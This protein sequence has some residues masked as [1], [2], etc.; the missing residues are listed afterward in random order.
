M[1]KVVLV[2]PP[3]RLHGK[4][5]YT[6]AVSNRRKS[7][8]LRSLQQV[9]VGTLRVGLFSFDVILV[10]DESLQLSAQEFYLF[11]RH[12]VVTALELLALSCADDGLQTW[13]QHAAASTQSGH[14]SHATLPESSHV[15]ALF[16]QLQ[17][18]FSGSRAQLM[19][20]D[21]GCKKNM[22]TKFAYSYGEE[23]ETKFDFWQSYLA[24]LSSSL[25]IDVVVARS[26]FWMVD[27]GKE[28]VGGRDCSDG[29]VFCWSQESCR[30]WEKLLNA[31]ATYPTAGVASLGAFTARASVFER[32]ERLGVVP[33]ISQASNALPGQCVGAC[34]Y[35]RLA[36]LIGR[37]DKFPLH[38]IDVVHPLCMA[39]LCCDSWS[40]QCGL[41]FD[42]VD[43]QLN[44]ASSALR[45]F[46]ALL[47]S[48]LKDRT[49]VSARGEVTWVLHRVGDDSNLLSRG[50]AANVNRVMGELVDDAQVTTCS[51]S[52]LRQYQIYFSE[53][54]VRLLSSCCSLSKR[55]SLTLTFQERLVLTAT[56]AWCEQTLVGTFAHGRPVGVPWLCRSVARTSGWEHPGM[57]IRFILD[58]IEPGHLRYLTYTGCVTKSDR[59]SV[60]RRVRLREMLLVHEQFRNCVEGP[61]DSNR[62]VRL[63]RLMI[64]L[65]DSNMRLYMQD[66]RWVP[67]SELPEL[68]MSNVAGLT[69]C[70]IRVD[71]S[72]QLS[73]ADICD[74][75][76]ASSSAQA[77]PKW[78]F[79]S[80]S[81][82]C[83]G[84]FGTIGVDLIRRMFCEQAREF[85][86]T[87]RREDI[88]GV[89]AVQFP[90]Q[91]AERRRVPAGLL[92]GFHPANFFETGHR[93]IAANRV[94]VLAGVTWEYVAV[95]ELPFA[96]WQG[97]AWQMF[98]QA[99]AWTS[100]VQA[101]DDAVHGRAQF[102]KFGNVVLLGLTVRLALIHKFAQARNDSAIDQLLRSGQA[103]VREQVGFV[104]EPTLLAELIQRKFRRQDGQ[105]LAVFWQADFLGLFRAESCLHR[106]RRLTRS[107]DWVS[108][109]TRL[110]N[111]GEF[112]VD[113]DWIFNPCGRQ[114]YRGGSF[115]IPQW[116]VGLPGPDVCQRTQVNWCFP[117]GAVE[118]RA[119]IEVP[120][121]I[122]VPAVLAAC[123]KYPGSSRLSETAEAGDS[124]PS[125]APDDTRDTRSVLVSPNLVSQNQRD[126]VGGSRRSR[127]RMRR[128]LPHDPESMS[129]LLV[130]YLRDANRVGLQWSEI[131]HNVLP[132]ASAISGLSQLMLRSWSQSVCA[133]CGE[134]DFQWTSIASI[135]A[136]G[137]LLRLIEALRRVVPDIRF[138]DQV[139]AFRCLSQTGDLDLLSAVLV[140]GALQEPGFLCFIVD[141]EATGEGEVRVEVVRVEGAPTC[142]SVVSAGML[143]AFPKV[144]VRIGLHCNC[145]FRVVGLCP[146]RIGMALTEFPPSLAVPPVASIVDPNDAAFDALEAT[147][148]ATFEYGVQAEHA[149]PL[150]QTLWP[151]A[152][153]PHRNQPR[154]QSKTVFCRFSTMILLASLGRVVL[155]NH[156]REKRDFVGC[157]L[158][159][160]RG[161][162]AVA[163][164]PCYVASIDLLAGMRQVPRRVA[165]QILLF[166]QNGLYGLYTLATVNERLR[167]IFRNPDKSWLTAL[168][169]FCSHCN[170][171]EFWFGNYS[172]HKTFRE[173]RVL[174]QAAVPFLASLSESFPR[175]PPQ[176][177]H[178]TVDWSIHEEHT[179]CEIV[180]IAMR[181]A[182]RKYP[183]PAFHPLPTVEIQ[184]SRVG[185]DDEDAE[186]RTI[187][188][189][190]DDEPSVSVGE[191]LFAIV[192]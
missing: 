143:L 28:Y 7:R 60:L 42:A 117:T 4:L 83:H 166:W 155:L 25:R 137:V 163:H 169:G 129:A 97:T 39:I 47:A 102:D 149:E 138:A 72:H 164:L 147:L 120:E 153:G 14:G 157:D 179:S 79:R 88:A 115:P 146:V 1:T 113:R 141:V 128:D 67:E 15:C 100:A 87:W 19:L 151:S 26:S 40:P 71:T 168:R 131:C 167:H 86:H 56:V 127:V 178:L 17:E 173:A 5:L 150:K 107:S 66:Q 133:L 111:C 181:E 161:E 140:K 142:S 18:V 50:W 95:V 118:G 99:T 29:R 116:A 11:V 184:E 105:Q 80:V 36:S 55:C 94:G 139:C 148:R 175:C 45:K 65:Y 51:T 59:V 63:M 23:T 49:A 160:S 54:L 48:S 172:A 8:L 52:S 3:A 159:L 177:R 182:F 183:G 108:N 136:D 57:A 31:G 41:N 156:F 61:S 185:R 186:P 82:Q 22:C 114:R 6:C 134:L 106:L 152:E 10:Q 76:F 109:Y 37:N 12:K 34:L 16:G 13:A 46:N 103:V 33:R 162:A 64:L 112:D 53:L 119:S 188:L 70:G 21:L 192:D 123:A 104:A 62:P 84:Y 190:S 89:S 125:L 75:F 92:V 126:C 38:V 30:A 77:H 187:E 24:I 20:L 180:S 144:P 27:L 96:L 69:K 44:A 124:Q 110:V 2:A 74:I 158:L 73:A 98:Q 91:E 189:E 135:A 35:T 93:V 165:G 176:P 81:Q 154:F 122:L 78:S 32:V 9:S 121:A 132:D 43:K 191:I 90:G 174:P 145:E 101:V 170:F 85:G 130:S 171:D 58:R 68:T